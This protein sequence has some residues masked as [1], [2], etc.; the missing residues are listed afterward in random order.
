MIVCLQNYTANVVMYNIST[1][2]LYFRHIFR[3]IGTWFL[4][5]SAI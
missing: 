1:D 3:N 2:F 4:S 5:I